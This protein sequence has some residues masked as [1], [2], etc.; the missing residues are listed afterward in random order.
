VIED[1]DQ[2]FHL[3]FSVYVRI[4]G[5]E[6]KFKSIGPFTLRDEKVAGLTR[7]TLLATRFNASQREA[8]DATKAAL[9]VAESTSL[10]QLS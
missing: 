7:T 9:E 1:K 3:E 2:L 10:W 8:F 6:A 4:Q 5:K